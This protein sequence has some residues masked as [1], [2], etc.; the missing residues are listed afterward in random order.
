[1]FLRK[2]ILLPLIRD[3]QNVLKDV[4][5]YTSAFD[6]EINDT[7]SGTE[8][9]IPVTNPKE[10][11]EILDDVSEQATPLEEA[12]L[13]IAS[14]GEEDTLATP[15]SQTI[16]PIPS[17]REEEVPVEQL[18]EELAMPAEPSDIN[19]KLGN[20]PTKQTGVFFF[21]QGIVKL[22]CFSFE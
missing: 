11:V 3:I 5:E 19:N 15:I 10:D 12:S 1:M 21:Y 18:E 9:P 8:S 7:S 6:D 22:N 13:P 4:M 17:S 16:P 2:L 20:S 14:S